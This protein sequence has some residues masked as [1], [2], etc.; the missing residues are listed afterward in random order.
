L[1]R[2]TTKIA[3]NYNSHLS[4]ALEVIQYSAQCGG[5]SVVLY[6]TGLMIIALQVTDNPNNFKILLN[7]TFITSASASIRD[8]DITIEM[9]SLTVVKNAFVSSW[10]F[11]LR[12]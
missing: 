6:N 4:E 2:P 7:I 1:D 12:M 11:E 9:A 10:I 8:K 3:T 5:Y